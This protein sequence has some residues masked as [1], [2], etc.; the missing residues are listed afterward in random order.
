MLWQYA[1]EG[2]VSSSPTVAGGVV[3]VGSTDGCLYA[4]RLPES[5]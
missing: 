5:K 2:P 3:Y 4:I 1:T